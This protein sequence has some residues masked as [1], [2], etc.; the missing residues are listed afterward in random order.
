MAVTDLPQP[1]SPTIA[2]VSFS[3]IVK[4]FPSTAFESPF[5]VWKYTRRS[6][7]LITFLFTDIVYPPYYCNSLGSNASRNPSPIKLIEITVSKHIKPAGIHSQ[8]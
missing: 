2:S 1:D 6:S 8:G 5:F 4:W 7:T 3:Y